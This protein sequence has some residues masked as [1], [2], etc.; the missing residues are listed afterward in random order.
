[1]VKADASKMSTVFFKTI[2]LLNNL[3]FEIKCNIHTTFIFS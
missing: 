2:I 3:K 1:M